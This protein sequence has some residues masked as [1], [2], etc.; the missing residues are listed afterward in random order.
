LRDYVAWH[1]RYD[2]PASN[3]AQRL[4]TVRRWIRRALDEGARTLVSACAGDGRDVLGALRPGDRVT[5]RLVELDPTLAARARQAAPAGIEVLEADAG[6]TDAYA[7]AVPADL[8]LLCGVF[9]NVTDDDVR[10]TVLASPMLCG[11]GATVVWTRHRREP[12]LTPQ[13]RAWFAEAG[14]EEL[15]FDGEPGSWSVGAARYAA[16]PV[17]FRAAMRLFTFVV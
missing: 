12:D 2:D 8:V 13:V 9:G 5:G 10:R 1:D 17:S 7:G 16:D 11:P 14:F 4:G 15:G 3:Q 6:S